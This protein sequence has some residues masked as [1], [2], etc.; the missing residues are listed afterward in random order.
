[1]EQIPVEKKKRRKKSILEANIQ[2]QFCNARLKTPAFYQLHFEKHHDETAYKCEICDETIVSK[3][4]FRRHNFL[5]HGIKKEQRKKFTCAYCPTVFNHSSSF[6][7]HKLKFHKEH[8]L[9]ELSKPVLEEDDKM[10]GN[11]TEDVER[12]IQCQFCNAGLMTPLIYQLHYEKHHDDTAYKCEICD[13]TIVSKHKFRQHNSLVHGGSSKDGEKKYKCP[14]CPTIF[15]HSSSLYRHKLNIHKEHYS[16]ESSKNLLKDVKIEGT[17][18]REVKRDMQCQLCNSRMMTPQEYQRHNDKYHDEAVYKC[19]ICDKS[20]VSK[21]KLNRHKAFVHGSKKEGE[22]KYMCQ[23]CP[24]TFQASNSLNHHNL[25]LHKEYYVTEANKEQKPLD[26]DTNEANQNKKTMK[27]QLCTMGFL[28]TPSAYQ[29]HYEK[30]H[31]Q[32]VYQCD[33]CNRSLTGKHAFKRH[34]S[35][36]ANFKNESFLC[37]L[38]PL[39]FKTESGLRRHKYKCHND[40]YVQPYIACKICGRELKQESMRTHLKYTHKLSEE[41]PCPECGKIFL[42]P[43]FLRRHIRAVHEKL[44]PVTCDICGKRFPQPQNLKKHIDGVHNKLKPY[45][46]KLCGNFFSQ[47]CSLSLHLKNVHK[48]V[49]PSVTLA[50]RIP[51]L[52]IDV[53]FHASKPVSSITLP[54]KYFDAELARSKMK[55]EI[56]NKKKDAE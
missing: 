23:H 46:C 47:T 5:V 35:G 31:D 52:K 41:F 44:L 21:H 29:S 19:E 37:H 36:H 10:E 4:N 53:D 30:Y 56:A 3:H 14:H 42:H 28:M 43:S 8:Y 25:R 32:T 7:R 22:K 13:E 48:V 54:D 55:L 24:S 1:M 6:N 33:I 34:Q 2:C 51:E 38:C 50:D 16:N 9:D 12:N 11:E 26:M 20:I 49:K 39:V 17:E 40:S 15:N 45:Q 27:C 18:I